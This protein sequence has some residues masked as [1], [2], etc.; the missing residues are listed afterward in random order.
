MILE[1]AEALKIC[2][3]GL[4]ELAFCGPS[5]GSLL[6]DDYR[7]NEFADEIERQRKKAKEILKEIG[8]QVGV[9]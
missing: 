5:V 1:H 6:N 2:I 7:G 4:H 9:N 3:D 8:I